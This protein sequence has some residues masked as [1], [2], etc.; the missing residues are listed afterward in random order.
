MCSYCENW[1]Y[2][3]VLRYMA[4]AGVHLEIALRLT[5]DTVVQNALH[6]QPIEK[7][8]DEVTM[9]TIRSLCALVDEQ[10]E[11]LRAMNP[12][13]IAALVSMIDTST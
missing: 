13:A 11:K 3:T 9:Q 5:R 12:G 7:K 4:Q 2:T 1:I 8:S 6:D 10:A